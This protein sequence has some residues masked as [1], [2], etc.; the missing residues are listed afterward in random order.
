MPA[1]AMSISDGPTPHRKTAV[2]RHTRIFTLFL[3]VFIWLV[4]LNNIFEIIAMMKRELASNAEVLTPVYIK[5]IKDLFLILSLALALLTEIKRPSSGRL[6]FKRPF[7]LASIF[8]VLIVFESIHS[9]TYLPLDVIL[10]GVRGYWT[11]LLLYIGAMYSEINERR[12]YPSL[13]AVF[14]LHIGLQGLQLITDVGFSVYGEHRSPGLFVNPSTAA[15]FALVVYFFSRQYGSR[16]V[17]ILAIVSVILSNSS[18]GIIVLILYYIFQTPRGSRHKL[19]I[20]PI[21]ILFALGAGYLL[22]T[23]LGTITGR[24]AGFYLS[25]TSRLDIVRTALSDWNIYVFGGGMGI[26]TSQALV[27]GFAGAIIPDNTFVETIY[28]MG[29]LPSLMLLVFV[30]SSLWYFE[31]YLIPFVFIGFSMTNVV[32]EMNPVIQ[33]ILVLMGARIGRKLKL[34]SSQVKKGTPLTK[35]ILEPN[36]SRI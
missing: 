2:Q 36:P 10:M 19:L 11:I 31:D 34:Q 8:L 35:P 32:F 13:A 3:I 30:C 6:W 24:Q 1:V 22:A 27:S 5:A 16:L 23:N 4:P 12:L 17:S 33:I 7:L 9:L 20:Y 29:I 28:N 15:A 26:A 25:A 14:F 18:A 21:Y